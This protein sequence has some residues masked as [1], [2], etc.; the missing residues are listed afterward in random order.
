MSLTAEIQTLEDLEL[1]NQVVLV[2]ADLDAPL[3]KGGELVD[4][5]RIASVVPTLKKLQE[6]GARVVVASR[7][8]EV[9]RNASGKKGEKPPGIE[10]AAARLGQLCECDVLLPDSCAG[11]SV[12][13]VLMDLR[14]TQICVLENLATEDDRGKNAEAL[15]RQLQG[16]VDIYL[17]DSVRAL[18]GESASTSILPRLMEF[19]AASPRMMK[20]LSA[21]DRINSGIDSPRVIIWGGN[22][23]SGRLD[24][25]RRVMGD[26]A[27]VL[28]AGVAA[29][30]VVR[31]Q[32]GAVGTSAVE[33]EYLAGAR[34]LAAQLGDRLVLPDDFIV[35]DSPKSADATTCA[36]TRVPQDKMVLDIGT[37]TQAKYRKLIEKSRTAV[38]C[39]TV[40]F[41][42][43]EAFAGGTRTICEALV[44]SSGFT[45]VAG[46]DSVAAARAT[47]ADL[48][49]KIDCVA[50]GGP[51]TLALLN[52]T[53]LPGLTA[54]RGATRASRPFEEQ[55][56]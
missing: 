32:G 41:H 40:G 54:L 5:Y 30:T 49:E 20:E 38:W 18:E 50:S 23:L 21:I 25:L 37:K 47:S 45:M 33:E 39:G 16:F 51:A 7:F 11:E 28:L 13:K 26:D 6:L 34:T 3:T 42:K 10:A 44:A 43:S 27:Q 17:A 35:A 53:K 8:G 55:N 31:A 15:A 52:D 36:A 48:L 14:S 29:N 19:R 22:T 1:E 9:N 56:E 24:L 46:D 2:R 12:K 4:D